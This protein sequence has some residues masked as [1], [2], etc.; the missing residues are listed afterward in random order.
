VLTDEP[1]ERWTAEMPPGQLQRARRHGTLAS[2]DPWRQCSLRQPSTA[3]AH[4]EP[5]QLQIVPLCQSAEGPPAKLTHAG[6]VPDERGGIERHPQSSRH[7]HAE[8][9]AQRA[10]VLAAGSRAVPA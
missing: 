6:S 4:R 8:S 10:R 5:G 3:P 7:E 1:L 2:A 9:L